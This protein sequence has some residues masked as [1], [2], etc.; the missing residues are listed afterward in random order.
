[1]IEFPATPAPNGVE[2]ELLDYGMFLRS[3]TGGS[4]LRVDRAGSRFKVTV[5]YPPMKPEV[6]RQFTA[7]LQRAKREGLRIEFPLLDATQGSP[8]SPQIDGAGQSGTTLNLKGLT[9]GYAILE[10]YWLTLIGDDDDRYLHQVVTGD[11]VGVDGKATLSIEPALRVPLANSS[12]VLLAQPTVDGFLI[13]T[14]GWSYALDRLVR[15]GGSITI[16]EA[17]G[18]PGMPPAAPTFDDDGLP[19][20]DMDS[21]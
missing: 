6:A 5:S 13:D 11:T 15:L 3:P 18:L 2:V 14:V 17:E 12:T 19:T 20:F 21:V 16:E 7:R 8:G 10:G 1:V 9:N 4:T